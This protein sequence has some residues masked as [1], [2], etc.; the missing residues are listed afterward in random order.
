MRDRE[1]VVMKEERVIVEDR[2]EAGVTSLPRTRE[3]RACTEVE[4]VLFVTTSS[5]MTFPYKVSRSRIRCKNTDQQIEEHLHSYS[6][7]IRMEGGA[8]TTLWHQLSNFKCD[9]VNEANLSTLQPTR[10]KK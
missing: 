9:I 1:S 7:A 6:A 3:T 5:M 2:K 4:L 10:Y 8:V